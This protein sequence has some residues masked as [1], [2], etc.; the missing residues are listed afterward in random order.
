MADIPRKPRVLVLG[1]L[2]LDLVLAPDR[3]IETGTD[4][5]G[6]VGLR[7]GGSAANTARWLA[8]LGVDTQLVCAVGRDGAGRSLVAQVARDG[9]RVRPARIAGQRTG[10]IGLLVAAT[11]ERSFVADRRAA[12]ALAP[13]H[14]RP[15]WFTGLD[16]VHVPGYSLMGEPIAS[17]ARAAVGLARAWNAQVSSDLSSIGPLL[18][19][20]R[21]AAV[22][23]VASISPDILFATETEAQAFLGRDAADG[24]VEHASIAVIKRGSRGARVIARDP[25]G[26]ILRF[27]VATPHVAA[28]DTTGAGDAFAAGF[29]A[30]WLT[31]RAAGRHAP[32]A[33]HRA[34]VAGHRAAARQLTMPKQELPAG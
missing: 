6:S 5:P 4:V 8:R 23:L 11:G 3:P 9:V 15:E 20:G 17:A 33:L 31:A 16:L 30:G 12:L 10:R 27:D 24:M 13:D 22:E 21:R 19:S 32:D 25:D 14:L 1:D 7:Q 29:I 26:G 2:V 28:T 18:S 34:T